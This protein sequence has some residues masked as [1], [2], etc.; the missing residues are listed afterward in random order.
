M[1]TSKVLW[2]PLLMAAGLASGTGALAQL[3]SVPSGCTVVKVGDPGGVLGGTGVGVI[4]NGSIVEMS[5]P[6]AGGNFTLSGATANY[7]RLY[8]DLSF[9]TANAPGNPD[10]GPTGA[11]ATVNVRSFNKSVRTPS[12]TTAPST[13]A[14]ARSKGRVLVRYT[15]PSGCPGFLTFD[16]LKNWTGGYAPPIVGPNC[17]PSPAALIT[18]SVDQVSSDNALDAIGSDL[19]YWTLKN[20]NGTGPD[21]FTQPGNTFYTSA[22]RSSI[23]INMLDPAFTTWYNNGNSGPYVLTCSYGRVNTTNYWDGGDGTTLPGNT[24]NVTVTKTIGAVA[25]APTFTTPVPTCLPTNQSSFAVAYTPVAGNSYAWSCSNA[26]WGLSAGS[27]TL[28]VTQTGANPATLTLTVTSPCGINTY[29]YAVNRSLVGISLIA[30]YTCVAPNTAFNLQVPD[31][32]LG[33]VISWSGVTWTHNDFNAAHSKVTFIVPAGQCAGVYRIYANTTSCTSN[34]IYVDINVKP[35]T[36]TLTGPTC[37]ASGG[38][39]AVTYTS[40]AP[41]GATSYTWSNNMGMTGSSS[42]S[43]IGYTPAG[44]GNGSVYV[45]ANGTNGCNSNQASLAVYRNPIAPALA[46]INIPVCINVGKTGTATFSISSPQPGATYTWTFPAG[47]TT[48]AMPITGNPVTIATTG[49]P[50]N[51]TCS[52]SCSTGGTCAPQST[53]FSVNLNFIKGPG[54]KNYGSVT[55]SPDLGGHQTISLPYD[56]AAGYQFQLV[57]CN[58]NTVIAGPQTGA[59]FDMYTAGASLLTIE[60]I[61]PSPGCGT[62]TYILHPPCVSTAYRAATQDPT[63]HPGTLSPASH[64]DVRISPNPND[65]SFTL[66]IPQDLTTGTVTVLDGQGRALGAPVRVVRGVNTLN[67]QQLTPGIYQVRIELDGRVST[68]SVVI[69]AH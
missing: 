52:V 42:T 12:E 9:A 11:V 1:R 37:V 25:A 53:S 31:D 36:P 5:D 58:T 2:R 45:T 16:V 44:T 39:A 3:V 27:G 17:F 33:N 21:L 20:A 38:G 66:D 55:V 19:Y 60:V 56:A 68:R 48:T 15:L 28:N 61:I 7:W 69:T 62:G 8:G 6:Y 50:G 18:Y 65:G 35:A 29:N 26:T 54:A 32:A 30:Q 22:D 24:H 43:T 4:S 23:T 63:E 49:T 46:N 14:M 51:Y 47:L 64:G 13:S 10:Q 41:C 34:Q 67:Y 57:D 40:S 59:S